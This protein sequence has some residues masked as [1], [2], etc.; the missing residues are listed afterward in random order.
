MRA[1]PLLALA[2][3]A[4]FAACTAIDDFN[5]FKF[6]TDG[7]SGGDML[8]LPGFGQACTD[9]CAQPVPLRPLMCVHMIGNRTVTGGICTRTC[10]AG[11]GAAACSD[12]SDAVCVTVESTDLCLPHCDASLGR[13]CRTGFSCCDNHNVV[14]GAGACAPPTTDLCH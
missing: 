5:K 8:A 6:V 12:F 13:N 14:T 10:T 4:L 11:A 7:G 3:A 2:L 9:S 1:L